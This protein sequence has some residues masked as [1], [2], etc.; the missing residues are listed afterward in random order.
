[1]HDPGMEQQDY[2]VKIANFFANIHGKKEF[3]LPKPRA[4]KHN[5]QQHTM[6]H[7]NPCKDPKIPKKT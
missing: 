7:C 1:M 4:M 3:D 5:P 6:I 2:I